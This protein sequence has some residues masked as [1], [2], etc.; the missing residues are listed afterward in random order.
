MFPGSSAHSKPGGP[1]GEPP[2]WD[3]GPHGGEEPPGWAAEQTDDPAAT[4]ALRPPGWGEGKH[5]ANCK[6]HLS[7]KL[8]RL[9]D[10]GDADI[11]R[12][13][14]DMNEWRFLHL[15]LSAELNSH[16]TGTLKKNPYICPCL[17]NFGTRTASLY[18]K[19]PF[20][21]R[22]VVYLGLSEEE[23]WLRG[24]RW[25]GT[26]VPSTQMQCSQVFWVFFF[27][28]CLLSEMGLSCTK[29]KWK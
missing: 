23:C 17:E 19:E 9:S 22:T 15:F 1:S 13:N 6:I 8:P 29:Y 21:M 10:Y 25:R 27:K 26:K 20:M 16:S 11:I 4:R 7:K 3:S 24:K 28:L 14:E 5:N 2:W 18:K 12:Y